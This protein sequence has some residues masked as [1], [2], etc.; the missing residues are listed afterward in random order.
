M[1]SFADVLVKNLNVT[2][3]PSVS[4]KYTTPFLTYVY[5]RCASKT[6]RPSVLSSGTLPSGLVPMSTPKTSVPLCGA[7]LDV[8][9][10]FP[11][12]VV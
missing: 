11:V 3:G 1:I 8:D 10:I 7:I 5:R 9:I 6:A 2:N 4:A 12:F